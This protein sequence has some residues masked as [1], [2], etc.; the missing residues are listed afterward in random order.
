[1]TEDLPDLE[2]I[3][4]SSSPP[5]WYADP[6]TAGQYRYWTGEAWTADTHWPGPTAPAATPGSPTAT[7]P[8]MY[9]PAG[10]PRRQWIAAI[11]AGVV[12]LVL[13]A[14]AVGYAIE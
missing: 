12:A 13:V 14:G 7:L 8:P 6:W 9:A 11:V 2:P 10:N 1:M 3:D 5:G 4:V